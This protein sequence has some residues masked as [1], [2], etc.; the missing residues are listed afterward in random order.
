MSDY[1]INSTSKASIYLSLVLNSLSID[2][3]TS[4]EICI[5]TIIPFPQNE[6]KS[7]CDSNNYRGIILSSCIA[8]VFDHVLLNCNRKAFS[9]SIYNLDLRRIIQ[10]FNVHLL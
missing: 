6:L 5:G 9:T 10:L 4:E 7:V 2:G 1:I 8:K 3:V